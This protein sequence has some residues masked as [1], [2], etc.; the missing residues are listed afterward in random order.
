MTTLEILVL[1]QERELRA[2]FR[3]MAKID[4]N[5]NLDLYIEKAYAVQY[6]LKAHIDFLEQKRKFG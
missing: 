3:A 4:V 6:L 1:E 5:T 2:L